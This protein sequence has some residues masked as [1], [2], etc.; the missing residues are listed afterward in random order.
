M[1]YLRDINKMSRI[2]ADRYRSFFKEKNTQ[3]FGP[4]DFIHRFTS[5]IMGLLFSELFWPEFIEIDNMVFL[6]STFED[7]SDLKRLNDAVMRYKGDRHKVEKSF[8]TIEV[9]S[10]FGARME[11]T[12]DE[13]DLILAKILATMWKARL[14]DKFPDKK[15]FVNVIGSEQ[16]G[17][18]IAVLF[19]QV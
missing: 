9:P 2:S 8:N 7:K 10:I 15:F 14:T 3:K 16:T 12:T 6:E 13:E 18:E 19:H 4:M 5:P 11:D 17:G 1:N